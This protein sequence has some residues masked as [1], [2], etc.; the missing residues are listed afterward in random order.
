MAGM[1]RNLE[2]MLSRRVVGPD[3]KHV[4][5]LE[6]VIAQWRDG[7]LEVV[8]Y[9]I[10]AYAIL[11]RLAA[12]RIGRA[13]LGVFGLGRKGGAWRVPWDKLDVADP[14]RPRLLCAVDELASADA[15]DGDEDNP[16][17]SGAG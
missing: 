6:E 1:E 8:E 15:D 16:R 10:G 3:G 14:S 4:G 2:A 7:E 11:E 12:L 9:R 13:I 5:L 17:P